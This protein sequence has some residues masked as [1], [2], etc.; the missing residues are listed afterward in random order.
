VGL[1][2]RLVGPVGPFT[3]WSVGPVGP[4]SHLKQPRTVTWVDV[5]WYVVLRYVDVFGASGGPSVTGL[6]N[7]GGATV[8]DGGWNVRVRE[9]SAVVARVQVARSDPLNT[10]C[11]PGFFFRKSTRPGGSDCGL[12][13]SAVPV[14]SAMV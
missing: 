14:A 4:V 2:G 5:S 12:S 8:L 13:E 7:A 10:V 3:T 6:V 9:E 1:S 11:A